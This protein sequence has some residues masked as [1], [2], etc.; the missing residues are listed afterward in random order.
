[1]VAQRTY[2]PLDVPI[3]V[4]LDDAATGPVDRALGGFGISSPGCAASFGLTRGANGECLVVRG[5]QVLARRA[6]WAAAVDALV[7]L[8]NGAAV[9]AFAGFAVHAGVVAVGAGAIAF[10]GVSGAGKS[11]LTAACLQAGARYVSDEALCVDFDTGL[12]VPY[13][14]P[15][16]LS[17]SSQRL[18]GLSPC[19]AA[20][21]LVT[22]DE[23]GARTVDAPL[24][25][26]HV[27]ALVRTDQPPCLVPLPRSSGLADLL[28]FSFNHYK[29]PRAAF[30]LA[31]RL[32]AETCA[33]RLHYS[34]PQAAA[35]LLLGRFG[36]RAG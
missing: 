30:E 27:V 23:L 14:K 34:S 13:P 6:S 4:A 1:L 5:E 18:L 26:V 15:I 19:P 3:A 20:D 32:A 2:R 8:V 17:A 28:R 25:L 16:R 31:G 29:R 21:A 24:P 11:T 33:W 12:V 36:E 22:A 7:T 10:P 35:E 9:G